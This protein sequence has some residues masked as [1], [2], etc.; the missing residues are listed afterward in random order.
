MK[1]IPQHL[2]QN[3]TKFAVVFGMVVTCHGQTVL[4][5]FGGTSFTGTDTPGNNTGAWTDPTPSWNNISDDTASGIVDIDGSA[6]ALAVDF[7]A[8]AISSMD[9]GA[10]VRVA[11][12]IGGADVDGIFDGNTMAESQLVRDSGGL[13]GIGLEL[14]GLQAGSYEFYLVAN[15]SDS[16]FNEARNM[17]VYYS[18]NSSTVTDFSSLTP[19]TQLNDNRVAWTEGETYVRGTFTIAT[20][21]SLYLAVESPGFVGVVNS[22]EVVAVPEPS[23]V[24]LLLVGI[25]A[26]LAFRNGKAFHSKNSS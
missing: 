25:V 5:N 8:G 1:I 6:T 19:L 3:I 17:D 12:Y 10:A 9:Y 20:G 23:T 18:T 24:L 22:L 4:F 21:E 13:I 14:S 11:D 2:L 16:A 7:G 26:F 15:R